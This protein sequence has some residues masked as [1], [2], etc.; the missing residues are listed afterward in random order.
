M[1]E[2]EA[3][4]LVAAYSEMMSQAEGQL[5]PGRSSQEFLITGNVEHASMAEAIADRLTTSTETC[6]VEV[7]SENGSYFYAILSLTTEEMHGWLQ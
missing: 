1:S 2:L 6:R 7:V 3:F 5:Q 4:C